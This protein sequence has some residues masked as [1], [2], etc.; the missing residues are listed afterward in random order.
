MRARGHSSWMQFTF[1]ANWSK[2]TSV[3]GG[4]VDNS[5]VI[6]RVDISHSGLGEKR[7]NFPAVDRNVETMEM[8]LRARRARRTSENMV[9]DPFDIGSRR[10]C[11]S[12]QHMTTWGES[13][14]GWRGSIGSLVLEPS[15][16]SRRQIIRFATA[17]TVETAVH[18]FRDCQ[19]GEFRSTHNHRREANLI[20]HSYYCL[21]DATLS[22]C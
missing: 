13:L 5:C 18:P 20:R 15:L 2:L 12:S 22:D 17:V 19:H 8:S 6:R 14:E 7:W 16:G 9:H 21:K 3:M 11:D 10:Q 1:S 4:S